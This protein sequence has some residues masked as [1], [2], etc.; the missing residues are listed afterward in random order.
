MTP[1]E[2][3][4]RMKVIERRIAELDYTTRDMDGGSRLTSGRSKRCS[5]RWLR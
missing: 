2:F 1:D 5:T 3:E 4:N